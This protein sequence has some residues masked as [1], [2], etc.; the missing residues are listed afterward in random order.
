ML[1]TFFRDQ[2]QVE[3]K[4]LIDNTT[5]VAYGNHMWGEGGALGQ[6]SVT[7]WPGISGTKQ[8]RRADTSQ[9]TEWK[10]DQETFEEIV[11]RWGSPSVDLLASR[12]T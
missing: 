6:Q 4:V 11:A 12:L 8:M 2:S 3:I 9:K 10:L 5:A 7:K 1:Q